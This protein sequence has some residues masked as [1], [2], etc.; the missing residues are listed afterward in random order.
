MSDLEHA[1]S[2]LDMGRGDL[3]AL[4]G[5][6]SLEVPSAKVSLPMKFSVS[7]LNKLLKNVSKLGLPVW[8]NVILVLMTLWHFLRL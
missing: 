8:E 2:L 6:S 5:M 7:M 4:R 1:K 3:N